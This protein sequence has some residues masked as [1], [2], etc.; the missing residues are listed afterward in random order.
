MEHYALIDAVRGKTEPLR[1]GKNLIGRSCAHRVDGASFI[2]LESPNGAVSRLQAIVELAENGDAWISD[3]NSTNGTFVAVK[4]GLGIRLQ[5][6]R[7]YQLKPGTRVTFGDAE[8]VF[9]DNCVLSDAC[10]RR[11]G[12]PAQT[13]CSLSTSFATLPGGACGERVG[14]GDGLRLS[15]ALAPSV[16]VA[17]TEGLS[18]EVEAHANTTAAC[19][20]HEG[21][22]GMSTSGR[23]ESTPYLDE[24]R[25]NNR[26]KRSR[27]ICDATPHGCINS[28]TTASIVSPS[29]HPPPAAAAAS[30]QRLRRV[31][32][33]GMDAEA[34]G[35]AQKV[36]RRNGWC[37]TDSVLDADVLIVASP[38]ARTPKFLVAVGRGIPV[39][40]EAFLED[41]DVTRLEKY[42][43]S[44]S[45]GP[46]AYSAEDLRKVVHRSCK[47]PLLQG[48]SF[49]LG[50]LPP[51]ARS[52]AREVITGCG[53]DT[54]RRQPQDTVHLTEESLDKLYDAVLRGERP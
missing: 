52:V 34:K 45:H 35:R 31:C 4:E 8:M 47:T 29:P 32:Y 10:T 5:P 7:F 38:A 54:S 40:T 15:A 6:E 3:C 30:V 26:K 25:K 36:A 20:S 14:G 49:Q 28:S 27:S 18:A 50:A 53:G 51:K 9:D 42:V 13:P 16:D 41:G 23:N 2:G 12:V 11:S 1:V 19:D 17:A 22:S 48:M 39:V 33:S 21:A 37:T 46:N 44:L 43:P 24:V